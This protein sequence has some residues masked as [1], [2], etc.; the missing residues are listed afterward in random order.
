MALEG[1]YGACGQVHGAPAGGLRLGEDEALTSTSVATLHLPGHP[2]TASVE[3]YV[4][5][6]EAEQLAYPQAR[7]ERENVERLKAV[8]LGA[9]HLKELARLLGRERGDLFL[10]NLRRV[11]PAGRV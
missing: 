7:G 2:E 11:D 1:F 4:T 10:A 6:P 8:A 3:V 5:P 9:G